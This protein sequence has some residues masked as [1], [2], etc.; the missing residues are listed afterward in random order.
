MSRFSLII[1]ILQKMSGVNHVNLNYKC[2]KKNLKNGGFVLTKLPRMFIM[3]KVV[4]LLL[5]CSLNLH[6]VVFSQQKKFDIS[7]REAALP[8]VFRYLH[9]M[10]DYKFIY[11]SDAVKGMGRVTVDMKDVRLEDVLR[12]VLKGSPFVYLIEDDLVIIREKKQAVPETPVGRI[13]AGEVVDENG[14]VIPGVTVLLKGTSIGGVTDVNGKFKFEVPGNQ[15]VVLVFSFVGMEKQEVIYKEEEEMKVVMKEDVTQMEEVVITGIFE[16]RKEGFTGSA[17]K[18]TNEDIRKMTSG[19]V[20]KALEMFDPGFKMNVSNMSGA[21]PNAIPEFQMRGQ[22]NMGDYQADD[23]VTLRGDVNTRPNQPLFVLDGVIGVDATVIMDLDPEQ[24]ESIT[25]LKDAAATVI[26]GSEAANGVVVVE[27]K[28]PQAGKLRFTYNGNYKLEV[29]DLS[30]YHLT[31]AGEKLRIEEMAGYYDGKSNIDLMRYYAHLKQEVLRGVNTY[32]LAEPLRT[33]FSHRHGINLEGGDKAL[34][35]KVYLGAGFTPGIM[36]KT[37]LNTKSGR[38][39]IIYRFSK[40]LVSNQLGIDY[41]KGARTSPY[42][43]FQEYT[44][45]NPYYRPYD[46]NGNIRKILDEND[47]S[48]GWYDSKTLNPLYNTQFKSMNESR[49]FEVREALKVEY[50]P[51]ENMRLSLDFTLSKSNGKVEIFKSAQHTDFDGYS[52]PSLKGSFSQQNSE[53]YNYRV[54]L[55]GSYN[56]TL[57]NDHLLSLYA[58]YNLSENSTDITTLNMT[59]FPNDRLDEVYLGTTFKDVNGSE[60]T[61]RALGFVFTLNYSWK[62]RYAV[63]YSMRIDAS[64]QFGENNRFAPFWSAG[65]RWNMDKEAFIRKLGIFDELVLR[66]SYGLT[67]SQGFSP[68]QSLQLYTYSGMMKTYRSSDVIGTKLYSIGNPDLKWQKT[69][70]YNVSLDFTLLKNLVS[71]RLEYYQKLTTNTLLDYSL[72]PSIGFSNIK[73][74]LGSISNKGVEATLRIMPYSD[75]SRQAYWNVIVTGAHNQSR[76]KKISNALKY[77]NEKQMNNT[78]TRPLPR[79]ESGYSQTIIWAVPS[80]GIDPISGRE[81]FLTREGRLTNEW[82]AADQIPMGDTEP[83]FSGTFSTSFNYR[84]FGVTLSG[85]YKWG[86][87]MYNYTLLD[88]VENANLRMNVDRRALTDRWQEVGNKAFFKK[89]DGEADRVKTKASSRFIMDENEFALTTVNLSYRMDSNHQK[90]LNRIGVSTLTLGMYLEDILRLSTV[91]IERGIEY[92]FS[93]QVSMSLNIVF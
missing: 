77:Q 25:L 23:V 49:K 58:R 3:M 26:Y 15:Q 52:D 47:L 48:I 86:G 46:E 79:Y 90:F 76:I 59:G 16:R 28:A 87:Q 64:S 93:H 39:D 9:Q 6:A 65:L 81:V 88:K 72:A 5:V 51:I 4:F 70:N 91:K 69:K 92:P 34:R 18:I 2:M 89:I 67:G 43:S 8:E 60:G 33:S 36:K 56:K 63:D 37:D 40:F 41:S 71:A 27:T 62:Q 54:S 30:V 85:K 53:G 61:S 29:P 45:L 57:G 84:G 14:V 73:D 75:P 55:T 24:V 31:N 20:L 22:A 50:N 42:G 11:D 80:L 82:N 17:T 68:Y 35:Y 7:M 13:I 74:N 78:T 38:V 44:L 32:W 66:G 83:V 21:N 19:N 12:N 1:S 10:S